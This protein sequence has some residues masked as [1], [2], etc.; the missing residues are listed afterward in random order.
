MGYLRKK[1]KTSNN[2]Y[3]LTINII[4]DVENKCVRVYT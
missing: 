2:C 4:T 1:V 3:V